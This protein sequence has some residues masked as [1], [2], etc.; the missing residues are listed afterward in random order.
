MH[1]L[2]IDGTS[3]DIV[4]EDEFDFWSTEPVLIARATSE[5]SGNK[6]LLCV[7]LIS[8]FSEAMLIRLSKKS[9][10]SFT[11]LWRP[12]SSFRMPIREM[13]TFS[14]YKAVFNAFFVPI[15]NLSLSTMYAENKVVDSQRYT[16]LMVR[17]VDAESK[18]SLP[19]TFSRNI[20]PTNR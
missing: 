7:K 14:K 15:L 17:G 20:M 1:V 19:V 18:I 8:P 16:G 4:D 3:V 6:K 9:T 13:M 2:C 10:G 11:I 12:Q 5:L